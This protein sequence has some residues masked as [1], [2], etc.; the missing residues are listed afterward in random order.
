MYFPAARVRIM[1]VLKI[2]MP[3]FSVSHLISR[4]FKWSISLLCGWSSLVPLIHVF[5]VFSTELIF[6]TSCNWIF[7]S[8]GFF[9]F[10]PGFHSLN[11]LPVCCPRLCS[12]APG[13]LF[14]V[15]VA[16]LFISFYQLNF[17]SKSEVQPSLAR[18]S[19]CVVE[20]L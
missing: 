7:T 17:N 16:S 2:S 1:C 9:F 10:N 19:H 11:C 5:A 4:H 3:I 13:A 6:C 18:W 14:M 8:V 15:V 12:F 20:C